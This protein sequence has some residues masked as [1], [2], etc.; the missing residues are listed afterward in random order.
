MGKNLFPCAPF[1]VWVC[2]TQ[3]HCSGRSSECWFK[4]GRQA[5][6]PFV[7]GPQHASGMIHCSSCI[8]GKEA[9][10]ERVHR[11]G[12]EEFNEQW[13]GSLQSSGT[14]PLMS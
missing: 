11:V 4:L 6:P 13:K 3:A 1:W 9:Y 14:M 10:I 8:N 7:E 12:R 2:N 5:A